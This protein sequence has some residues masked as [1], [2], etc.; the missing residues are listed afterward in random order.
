MKIPPI[1]VPKNPEPA[2]TGG[3][4]AKSVVAPFIADLSG[5]IQH[6]KNSER[7]NVN[8]IQPKEQNL[9][10]PKVDSAKDL[11][12]TTTKSLDVDEKA[13]EENNTM[14]PGL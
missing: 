4:A 9:I 6:E 8:N 5:E 14:R 3:E 7:T 1:E 12:K 2:K 13:N 11:R 10:P